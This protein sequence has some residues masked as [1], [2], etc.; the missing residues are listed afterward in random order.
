MCIIKL[1]QWEGGEIESEIESTTS[2]YHIPYYH[3]YE[4][5]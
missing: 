4:Y 2:S 5:E 3:R 1:S